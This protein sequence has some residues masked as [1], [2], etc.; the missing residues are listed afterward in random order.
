MVVITQHQDIIMTFH[1]WTSPMAGRNNTIVVMIS[2]SNIFL[3][4]PLPDDSSESEAAIDFRTVAPRTQ[5]EA[6]LIQ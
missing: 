4:H 1:C 5:A 3:D 2:H 6:N